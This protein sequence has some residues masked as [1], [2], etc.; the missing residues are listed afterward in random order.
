[1]E[2]TIFTSDG[3]TSKGSDKDKLAVIIPAAAAAADL[4]MMT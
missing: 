2:I 1:M 4:N 3:N